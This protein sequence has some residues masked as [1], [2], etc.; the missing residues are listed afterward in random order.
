MIPR[1]SMPLPASSV[2]FWAADRVLSLPSTLGTRRNLPAAL[3]PAQNSKVGN[4]LGRLRQV[5][6]PAVSTVHSC[7]AL[8]AAPR[9]TA[10]PAPRRRGRDRLAGFPVNPG[11][12]HSPPDFPSLSAIPGGGW[13][14]RLPA[15]QPTTATPWA[16]PDGTPHPAARRGVPWAA[17]AS[18]GLQREDP[19]AT[20]I[21]LQPPPPPRG[22]KA[23]P[24][25]PGRCLLQSRSPAHAG[26]GRTGGNPAS[27]RWGA[28]LPRRR[29]SR[30]CPASA[31][32]RAPGPCAEAA[33]RPGASRAPR[34]RVRDSAT[35]ESLSPLLASHPDF[36][37]PQAFLHPKPSRKPVTVHT[38]L[39][40]DGR[41][42]HPLAKLLE[43]VHRL[44]G[45]VGP[46]WEPLSDYLVMLEVPG[47]LPE[48]WVMWAQRRLAAACTRVS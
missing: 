45:G 22:P 11:L 43:G 38:H 47:P 21:P 29:G 9:R 18:G 32:A 30:L 46:E 24:R 40:M 28:A 10:K 5:G 31:L 7:L 20:R 27:G 2:W 19:S 8:R 35:A 37:Y 23:P 3:C 36:L 44:Q 4:R 48:L 16:D 39:A 13:P 25:R 1:P 33:A 14:R 12:P 6:S 41:L 26:R 42:G 15:S 17:L 34:L